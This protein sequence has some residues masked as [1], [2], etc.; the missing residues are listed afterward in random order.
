MARGL[1]SEHFK[2]TSS[3]QS[4]LI[5]LILICSFV[6]NNIFLNSN[7]HNA[8]AASVWTQ[9]SDADFY[10]GTFKNITLVGSG[11]GAEL[12]LDLADLKDWLDKRSPEKIF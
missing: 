6:L 7:L 12:E 8:Q 4:I 9:T 11:D 1:K 3:I 10:N 2:C 5:I